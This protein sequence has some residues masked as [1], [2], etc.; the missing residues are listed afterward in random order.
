MTLEEAKSF[1]E[2]NK[3]SDEV[4]AYLQGL[5]VVTDKAVQWLDSPEG[6]AALQ[7]KLDSHHTKSLETWKKKHLSEEIE[8]EVAKRVTERL[9]EEESP[10]E[11]RIRDLETKLEAEAAKRR[12]ET[13]KNATLRLATEKGIQAELSTWLTE[14]MHL[15]G[16]DEEGIRASLDEFNLLLK[17]RDSATAD[18]VLQENGRAP[19][20]NK[21]T[22]NFTD[23]P[24]DEKNLNVSKQM[25]AYRENP[26]RARQMA[27][28][29]GKTIAAE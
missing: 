18:K 27:A 28:A 20:Q 7:P 22:T 21:Q 3:D 17:A 11:K 23:N 4:K 5:P 29:A 24:W 26:Q 15:L 8:A 9:P 12:E 6:L 25:A 2:E 16:Q 14:R 1:L 19:V 10:Q 13:L